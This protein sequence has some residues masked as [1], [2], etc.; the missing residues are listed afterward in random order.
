MKL[1]DEKIARINVSVKMSGGRRV[2]LLEAPTD[3]SWPENDVVNNVYC[4][5]NYNEI[6]W[7]ISA[8]APSQ[9]GDAFVGLKKDFTGALRARRF[10]GGEFKVDSGNGVAR[11]TGWGK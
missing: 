1:S 7:Q 5:D 11:M 10:F 6:V 3:K 2:V 9:S 8:A 4:I